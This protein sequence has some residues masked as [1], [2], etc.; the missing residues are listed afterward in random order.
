MVY[1]RNITRV[2]YD[3]VTTTFL[4]TGKEEKEGSKAVKIDGNLE[5]G[6]LLF[7]LIHFGSNRVELV[8]QLILPTL[9][10]PQVSEHTHKKNTQKGI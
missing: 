10:F 1:Y 2:I 9:C 8:L 4:F 7:Q 6:I 3:S 5:E